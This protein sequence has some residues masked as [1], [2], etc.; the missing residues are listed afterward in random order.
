MITALKKYIHNYDKLKGEIFFNENFLI[1]MWFTKEEIHYLSEEN[2]LTNLIN[3]YYTIHNEDLNYWV[4]FH[5]YLITTIFPGT[6]ITWLTATMLH[7]LWNT[8]SAMDFSGNK[9]DVINIK[10]HKYY[11]IDT[12]IDW[13]TT[14]YEFEVNNWGLK[15]TK[16]FKIV[17]KEQAI[18]D[19]F[20]DE[21]DV[22]EWED[23]WDLELWRISCRKK[24]NIE[25]LLKLTEEYKNE[26][27]SKNINNFCNWLTT[28]YE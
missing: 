23:F 19:Y 24:I 8:T 1:K 2:I 10:W 11:Q 14:E 3:Q 4:L 25:E 16:T 13:K 5:C 26:N 20:L 17:T 22:F 7:W 27:L 28:K 6:Y 12:K 18:I 21:K 9:N 15:S